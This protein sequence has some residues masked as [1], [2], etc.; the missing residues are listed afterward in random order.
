MSNW[1]GSVLFVMAI[2][3]SIGLHEWGHFV[4]ARRFGMRAERF[5]L[6][7]GPTMWSMRRGETEYGVKWLLFGGF[8][9]I[10]GMSI[11][12]QRQPPVADEVFGRD[13]V[14][15]D[16]RAAVAS[17]RV[18]L[19]QVPAVPDRTW[20]RLAEELERRG[21]PGEERRILVAVTADRVGADA[22]AQEA[23]AVFAAVA[24]TRLADTGHVGDVRHRVLRGDHGRFFHERPAWQRA[25]VLAAG[26]TMHFVQAIVL[27]FVA[28]WVFGAEP[29][30]VVEGVIPGSPAATAGLQPGDRIVAVD[31][32]AVSGFEET[33]QL[34]EARPG[35]AVTLTVVDSD[36]RRE[37]ELT[38][39][40]VLEQMEAQPS[41]AGSGLQ[42]GDRLLAIDGE[43]VSGLA[44]LQ[45]AQDRGG[46]VTLTVERYGDRMQ[47][48][49][50]VDA[51]VPAPALGD[52]ADHA[53]GL[54]GFLPARDGFG[55][56]EALRATFV[57]E[58]SFPAL[59]AGT[60]QA[61]V[62]VFGPEGLGAIPAQ[63][64]GADRGVEGGAS[65]VG[66]TQLA[67]Q[68]TAV[69]GLFFLLGILASLNVFIGV[70]NLVPLPPL[71]GGHLAV[72]AVERGV[73]AVRA[74]RGRQPDY[75][76]D[77]RTVTAIAVPV[78]VLLGAV[79]LALVVLDV[80]NPL[81]LPQ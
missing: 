38:T 1:V 37:L 5:F 74:A 18:P 4:T 27:L 20:Q 46:D 70:F 31:G 12:D 79:F 15:E 64:A 25:I 22:T 9:R 75:R 48:I 23:A 66:L 45:A 62:D 7:F 51:T 44:Q 61:L 78:L 8:V 73:N 58:G 28:F 33:R 71:D 47:D 30:P 56:V 36:R 14:A 65:L 67:G 55:P 24:G 49:E 60:F 41:L 13:A 68:G 43:P 32:T 34:I 40:V 35:E 16:R 39:A 6:G 10:A 26:S 63:L 50:R 21:V 59:V 29:V 42:E 52:L 53:R 81:Q 77:P 54:A 57:G 17:Q 19:E 80:T 2:T 3:V 72:L 76:V 69:A 11:G